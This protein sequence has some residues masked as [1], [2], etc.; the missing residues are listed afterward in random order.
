MDISP[1][2]T[3]RTRLGVGICSLVAERNAMQPAQHVC[4][5]QGLIL[6]VDRWLL[7]RQDSK[8]RTARLDDGAVMVV[9]LVRQGLGP[10]F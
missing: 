5:L 4:Y 2:N 7:E 9:P 10:C 8:R 3:L 1:S 6:M